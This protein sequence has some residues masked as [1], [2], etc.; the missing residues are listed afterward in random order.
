MPPKQSGS[1]LAD[2]K[3]GK[4]SA[5][6]KLPGWSVP[7]KRTAFLEFLSN[8]KETADH[9]E[10]LSENHNIKAIRTVQGSG[11]MAEYNTDK[12]VSQL[13][14]EVHEAAE[15]YF[16]EKQE[17]GGEDFSNRVKDSMSKKICKEHT[18][19]RLC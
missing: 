10:G 8:I 13:M 12:K 1:A 2:P 3:P 4:R 14:W 16:K 6:F 11:A 17:L 5:S 9:Q 19:Q 7:C 15:A 18:L